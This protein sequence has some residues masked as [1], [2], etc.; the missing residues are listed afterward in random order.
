MSH[1]TSIT[2]EC[3]VYAKIPHHIYICNDAVYFDLSGVI[4]PQCTYLDKQFD[5]EDEPVDLH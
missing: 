5:N 4:N 1:H 2:C 3:T